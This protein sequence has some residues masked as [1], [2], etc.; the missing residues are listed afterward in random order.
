MLESNR[1]RRKCL[2]MF[3]ALNDL[4]EKIHIIEKCLH[5]LELDD[6]KDIQVS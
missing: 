6:L 1:I 4:S 2:D 3:I 5:E